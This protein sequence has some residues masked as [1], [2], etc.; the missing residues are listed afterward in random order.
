MSSDLD[1]TFGSGTGFVTTNFGLGPNFENYGQ[2]IAIQT[3]G[4]IVMGGYVFDNSS[5]GT[6]TNH[7]TL[8]RYNTDGSL[9]TSFGSGGLV[10]T[11]NFTTSSDD[12]CFSIAIYN[13]AGINN[14]KI[15]MCGQTSP[16]F[17]P[18]VPYSFVLARYTTTGS[19]DP[20]F[21]TLGS[22]FVVTNFFSINSN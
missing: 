13:N 21:G 2:S 17:A 12:Q 6:N 10:V 14:G 7:F 3:D 18:T 4:K 22:G 5:G 8:A 19:L 16:L 11:P 20:T 15:L 9:D 1:T